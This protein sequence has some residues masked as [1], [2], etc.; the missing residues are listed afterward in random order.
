[1]EP[2]AQAL[3]NERK[4]VLSRLRDHERIVCDLQTTIA[5]LDATLFHLGY[6]PDGAFAP[7]NRG[8]QGCFILANYPALS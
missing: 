8:R 4:N 2:V 7:R 6:Y 3:I 5:H 1:M